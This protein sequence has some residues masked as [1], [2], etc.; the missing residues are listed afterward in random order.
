L[1]SYFVTRKI[2]V[3]HFTSVHA[4]KDVRIFKKECVSLATR[5]YEVHLLVADGLGNETCEGV[6]IYDIGHVNGRLARMLLQPR[7]M[8]LALR[9]LRPNVA[10][11]HDPE[12]L[13][14]GWR[15]QRAGIP[16]VYDA[17]EDLPR[18]ILSKYYIPV[19]LRRLTS[20]VFELLEDFIARRLAGVIAAT[21]HIAWRFA[22]LNPRSIAV[23]NYSLQEEFELGSRRCDDGRTICYVGLISRIRGSVEMIRALEN[24]DARLILAGPFESPEMESELRRMPG[25]AKVDYRGTVNRACVAEIM[26]QSSVGLLMFHPEPNHVDSQPNKLFEY[27]AAGLAVVASDFP[28]WRS[29]LGGCDAV[30]FANPLDPDQI[31]SVINE[32]VQEPALARNMGELGRNAVVTRFSWRSEEVKLGEFYE[33]LIA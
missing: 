28:L 26:S 31:A 18:A 3:A 30:R 16:T 5:G 27:M 13:V 24:V 32:I 11:F 25:W 21:P 6:T 17:H 33:G 15:L 2:R 4:R 7:R 12:L 1:S 22:R 14:V 19:F 8:R 29:L 10:H 23:N 20:T 9:K